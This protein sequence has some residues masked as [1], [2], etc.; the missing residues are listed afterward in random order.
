VYPV[1]KIQN[2]NSIQQVSEISDNLESWI[3]NLESW[4]SNLESSIPPITVDISTG[5]NWA[6]AK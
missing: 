4:I 6:E 1:N 5:T 2:S 3:S